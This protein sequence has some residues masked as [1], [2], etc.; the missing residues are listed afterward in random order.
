MREYEREAKKIEWIPKTELGKKVLAG[1]IT[2]LN[3]VFDSKKKILESEIID[4]LLPEISEEVIEIKS[5]QRM[6]AYGRKQKMRAV[7]VIGNKNGFVG[8]GVGKAAETRGAIRVAQ[9]KAKL[10]LIRVKLGSGSWED[11]G[12]LTNS[13]VGNAFG[14]SGSTQIMIKPAPRGVGLVAGE[15]SRKVLTLAGIQ[16]AWTFTKGRTRN[17]LN[18]VLATIH[19]LNSLNEFKGAK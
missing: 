15:V 19:A 14:K 12:D 8:V 16:D 3:Q 17:V 18:M 4:Y 6:T 2:D 10:N 7:V 1:E 13:I 11:S 9:K 5:T